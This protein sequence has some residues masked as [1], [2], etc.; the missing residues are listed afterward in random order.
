MNR[1]MALT[2]IVV[3]GLVVIVGTLAFNMTGKTAGVDR[4]TASLKPDFKPATSQ[5][6][7]KD[8]ATVAAMSTQL[9]VQAI[10]ALAGKLHLTVPQFEVVLAKEYPQVAIGIE[11]LPADLAWFGPVVKGLQTQAGN[12]SKADSIPLSGIPARTVPWLL[13]IPSLLAV[14]LAA[15]GLA[16][17]VPARRSLAVAG[18]CGAVMIVGALACDV[19]GKATAVDDLHQAFNPYFTTAGVAHSRASIDRISA[20]VTQFKTQALPGLAKDFKAPTTAFAAELATDFPAVGTGLAQSSRIV[21][22]FTGLVDQTAANQNNFK[23]ATS[24]PFG[25]STPTTDLTWVFIIPGLLLLLPL[26][27]TLLGAQFEER[28]GVARTTAAVSPGSRLP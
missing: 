27:V 6:V 26:C 19:P 11:K 13:I 9:R 1:R 8:A 23:L 14:A 16:G 20:M 15:L 7:A 28:R 2:V 25:Q 4:L 21:T 18:V 10:P 22:E 24:I 3:T 12:F 17:R 5:Q